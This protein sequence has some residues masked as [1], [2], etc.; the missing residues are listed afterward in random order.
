MNLHTETCDA[1]LYAITDGEI[2]FHSSV[3]LFE[4]VAELA[5][6]KRASKILVDARFLSGDLPAVERIRLA[7]KG[8]DHLAHLGIHPSIA[9]VGHP[10][11]CNGLAVIAAQ[12]IGA[13]IQLFS[14][15]Q[16]AI[17]W[18]DKSPILHY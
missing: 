12:S 11:A 7:V 2:D 1:F 16:A 14:N 15:I 17:E 10:P 13:D 3:R 18:L 6:E 4:Q 9:I 8:T 5:A